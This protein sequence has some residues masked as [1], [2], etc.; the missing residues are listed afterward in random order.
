MNA[1]TKDN[2][3]RP[4]KNQ[5]L[6]KLYL[7]RIIL[8]IIIL[9][10]AAIRLHLLD[11]PMER[12]EGEYAYAGQLLLQGVPPYDQVYNMKLPGIYVVYAVLMAVF[13]QTHTGVH[14]GLLVIN[15]ATVLFLFLL[16][17]KLFT[18][19]AGL[20]AAASY[21]LMSM[22]QPVQGIFANA[23]HFVMFFAISGL[24]LLVSAA[25]SG[26]WSA[27]V[28]SAILLG[29]GFLTK[30]HG[31]AFVVF[32][33]LYLL[34]SDFRSKQFR[35]PRI[36]TRGAVFLIGTALPFGLTCLIL[37]KSG[38]FDKFWFWTFDYA[39]EYVSAVPLSIGLSILKSNIIS[40]EIL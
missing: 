27:L 7:P 36:I 9:S 22:G 13:G 38:V 25:G 40:I 26:G 20:V 11:V 29:A 21:A 23:E 10:A 6:L 28:A 31:A 1:M 32:G 18:P 19:F 24:C 35:W 37:W 17:K 34:I 33:F 30:Q 8:V 15:A 39:R 3:S 12:D 4:Q 16:T 14:L 2:K 5:S